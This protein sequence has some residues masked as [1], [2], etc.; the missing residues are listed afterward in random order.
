MKTITRYAC[1]I[2]GGEWE[3]EA[4]ALACEALGL[5]EPMP[6]L[7]WDEEVPAFGEDGVEWTKLRDVFVAGSSGW[8]F[9]PQRH[10]W[11]IVTASSLHVSHNI[12]H[13]HARGLLASAFD[14]RHGFDAFR[15]SCTDKD[16]AAWRKAMKDYGFQESDAGEWI[17]RAVRD[18]EEKAKRLAQLEE[19]RRLTEKSFEMFGEA[20]K[21]GRGEGG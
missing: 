12:D 7:S 3:S 1:E 4:D 21:L 16:A 19:Q 13:D 11:M 15:Y 9:K 8:S 2:C 5:P 10:E 14:P 20:M 6:W 18:T 17:L